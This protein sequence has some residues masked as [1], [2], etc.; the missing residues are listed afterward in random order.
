MVK[1]RYSAEFEGPVAKGMLTNAPISTKW[2]REVAVAIKGMKLVDAKKY[3]ERV[4]KHEDWIP[5]RRYNKKVAHRKGVKAGV[6]SGR[7]LDKTV[8]YFLKLIR[9]V[10]AN[11]QARG[12]T[13]EKLRIIHIWVGKGYRRYKRQP[14]GM[15]RIRRAKS[16]H[17]EMVVK[18]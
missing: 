13:V 18:E 1:K 10:E 15:F 14:K 3:L 4:L 2:A 12:L 7:F 8:K 16:T 17:V 11:A 5:I 9:N 6:K